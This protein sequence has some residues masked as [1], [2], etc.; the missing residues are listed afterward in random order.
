MQKWYVDTAAFSAELAKLASIHEH[1]GGSVDVLSDDEYHLLDSPAKRDAIVHDAVARAEQLLSGFASG[2]VRVTTADSDA[3]LFNDFEA[4]SSAL[5]DRLGR[6]G[7]VDNASNGGIGYLVNWG[8]QYTK[9]VQDNLLSTIL[10]EHP[11]GQVGIYLDHYFA[12]ITFSTD[13]EL[14]NTLGKT[15]AHELGHQIGMNHTSDGGGKTIAIPD[16][17]VDMMAQGQDLGGF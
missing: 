10:N 13:Q 4:P 2:L 5:P 11:G 17:L 9:T 1:P 14:I 3:V 8:K 12:G 6:S 7:E 15:I 16:A